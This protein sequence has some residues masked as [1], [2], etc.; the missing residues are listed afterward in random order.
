MKN[1]IITILFSLL[2]GLYFC[3][4]IFNLAKISIGYST[5]AGVVYTGS[6]LDY[7]LLIIP[8]LFVARVCISVLK[9]MYIKR[10]IVSGIVTGLLMILYA[11]GWSGDSLLAMLYFVCTAALCFVVVMCLMFKIRP[12]FNEEMGLFAG[13][14]RGLT[15]KKRLKVALV[16]LCV[17]VACVVYIIIPKKWVCLYVDSDQ[18]MNH[19]YELDNDV[20]TIGEEFMIIDDLMLDWM[21]YKAGW[22]YYANKSG[23][24]KVSIL[25]EIAYEEDDDWVKETWDVYVDENLYVH[26]DADLE[27]FLNV[28]GF[29]FFVIF[30]S[31]GI[32]IIFF[33]SGINDMIKIRQ[34]N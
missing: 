12:E 13:T 1:H 20:L 19:A 10:G 5:G 14:M 9:K 22:K 2:M 29:F 7:I 8:A 34:I 3:Y 6:Y 31:I 23:N 26:Y 25:S 32:S 33:V 24:T 30:N 21:D 27:Y 11:A 18:F 15:Y 17:C 16:L 4:S 28:Y